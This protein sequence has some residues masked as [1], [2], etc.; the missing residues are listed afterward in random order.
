MHI[1]SLRTWRMRWSPGLL[2]LALTGRTG[3]AQSVPVLEAARAPAPIEIDGR[4]DDAVW[5]SAPLAAHFTQRRPV[6]GLPATQRSEARVLYD[7]DAIIVAFRL[8]DTAPDSVVATLARRDYAGVSDWAHVFIDSYHD[9][10]T[11]FRFSVNP[12]GVKSDAIV[13]S[14]DEELE[15][16]GWDGVWEAAVQRDSAGWSAELRIPL[17]QLRFEAP[18]GGMQTWGIQFARDIARSGE[19][20]LWAAVSPEDPGFVSRFGELRGLDVRPARRL[21]IVPYVLGRARREPGTRAD[22]FFDPSRLGA[23]VGVDARFG[24]APDLT[25]TATLNPD[26]GQVEA[27]PSEV[28]LTGVETFLGE[29]RPFFVEGADIFRVGMADADFMHGPEE[30]FYSRRLGRPVQGAPP[31]DARFAD[32]QSSARILGAAKVSGKTAGGW[33]IG[34]LTAL[35]SA[36]YARFLDPAGAPGRAMVEPLTSYT[37]ARMTREVREGRAAFGG[38]LTATH[39]RLDGETDLPAAAYVGGV[40]G[41]IRFGD[42]GGW[43]ARG[44]LLGSRLVGSA[45]AIDAV[46]RNAVH[47]HQRPDATHLA[48]EPGATRLDGYSATGSVGK[49]DGQWRGLVAGHLISPGFDANDLG[50]HTA[51]DLARV[52][53]Q[54]GYRELRPAR[55]RR[56]WGWVNAW[57]AWSGGGE[58]T[59][60]AVQLNGNVELHSQWRFSAAL[61]REVATLSTTALRGGPALR[62]PGRTRFAYLISGDA[63]RALAPGITGAFVLSDEGERSMRV[64]PTL[65]IRPSPRLDLTL[66]PA[67]EWIRHPAQW[68]A[69]REVDGAPVYLVGALDQTIASLTMRMNLSFTR[70]LSLQVYAQPFA[71]EGRYGAIRE[72]AEPRAP[73]FSDRFRDL[74]TVPVAGAGPSLGIDRDGDGSAD[75][76]I[77]EPS[78]DVKELTLNAVLRW[79]MSAGSTLFVVWSHERAAHGVATGP[80]AGLWDQAGELLALPAANSLLVKASLWTSW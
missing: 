70:S 4:I 24:L 52:H 74:A 21:E 31:A 29:R 58:R 69:R 16:T 37:A 25:L 22:P 62:L 32:F 6:D 45:A 67:L 14:D 9:R 15:E 65:T 44:S 49:N 75:L 66:E 7:D 78:F 71:S 18:G 30:V 39:R 77:G 5:T 68:L 63:P 55:I 61:R 23:D 42:Q 13:L 48:Y 51:S 35:T 26:F 47:R 8:H 76:S 53:F 64:A 46:R 57:A 59:A 43:E 27:D 60:T 1:S 20:S 40:D 12:A 19:R 54:I 33:A 41:R 56:W 11:A 79:E 36:E 50:Y 2:L 10:R 34:A 17:T 28:N 38:V 73:G 3:A 72:V 80:D